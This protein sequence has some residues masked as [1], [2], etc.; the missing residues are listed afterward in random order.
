MNDYYIR[1]RA[2]GQSGSGSVSDPFNATVGLDKWIQKI[3][4]ETDV[5]LDLGPG[6]YPTIGVLAHANNQQ[7][8]SGWRVR[9]A[10]IGRTVLKLTEVDQSGYGCVL[11]SWFLDQD[12]CEVS[13]LTVD[14]NYADIGRGGRAVELVGV[15]LCGDNCAIRRV[16][17][18][19][20]CGHR[21]DQG[22]EMETFAMTVRKVAGKGRRALIEDCEVAEFGGGYV[23]GIALMANDGGSIRGSVRRCRV[24]FDK[25]SET[26]FGL[27]FQWCEDSDFSENEIY[28]GERGIGN[29]TG[30]NYNIRFRD[31]YFQ[32]DRVATFIGKSSS[33]IFS[34]NVV[35]LTRDGSCALAFYNDPAIGGKVDNWIVQ[36]NIFRNRGNTE[37]SY[38]VITNWSGSPSPTRLLVSDNL[39]DST[40]GN[41]LDSRAGAY[42][43]N[44]DFSGRSIANLL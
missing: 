18:V 10:G 5:T 4:D 23:N 16:R 8:K 25:V 17:V 38:G 42:A 7:L 37:G 26:Q 2:D 22:A 14:C 35:D 13:D 9:G 34:G 24:V 30:D 40:L 39:I 19:G 3:G 31:N 1:H 44:S 43:R 36:Q 33:C 11:S 41:V 32:P 21:V 6:L 15:M 20:A 27:N 12:N 29:D 28:G